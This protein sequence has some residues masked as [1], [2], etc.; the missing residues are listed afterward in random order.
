MRTADLT[1]ALLDYWVARA[2]G[3]P[4]DQMEIRPIQR[5]TESHCV[6][7][8]PRRDPIIGHDERVLGYSTSW[9]LTGPLLEKYK[10]D[11]SAVRNHWGVYGE[12]PLTTYYAEGPTPLIAIC[13]AM[14][15]AAFGDE[16]G[17]LP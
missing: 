2:E 14:V 15:R 10:L 1:G 9:A 3:V 5:S 7:R 16:V 12:L 6:W 8:N 13:R 11:V 4:A 17:D